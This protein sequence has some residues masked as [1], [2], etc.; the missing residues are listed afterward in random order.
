MAA[1]TDLLAAW[2]D[3]NQACRDRAHIVGVRNCDDDPEWRALE[4]AANAA[5]EAARAAGYT[6]E[7]LR[8]AGRPA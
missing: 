7:E 6:V 5:Y 3:A 4:Q 2:A 1:P 8:E